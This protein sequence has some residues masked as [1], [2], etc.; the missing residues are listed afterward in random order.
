M[1]TN[2]NTPKNTMIYILLQ[3]VEIY[4]DRIYIVNILWTKLYTWAY[5]KLILILWSWG[6]TNGHMNLIYACCYRVNSGHLTHLLSYFVLSR[7][8]YYNQHPVLCMIK[9]WHI[10]IKTIGEKSQRI[11]LLHKNKY[12]FYENSLWRMA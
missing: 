3:F 12:F 1:H 10:I 2:I 4:I 9:K 6:R 7:L 5:I 8:I 11:L